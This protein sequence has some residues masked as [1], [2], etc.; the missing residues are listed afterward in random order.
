MSTILLSFESDWFSLLEQGEK[1]FEYRKHFP[2]GKTTVYFYVSKPVMAITGIATFDEREEL[3]R[4]KEKFKDRPVTVQE[5]IA[6]M[7][8]DCRYAVPCLTFQPTNRLSLSQ[9]REDID[10]FIVPRMY[11]Y[12][13][14]LPLLD[15]LKHNLVPTGEMLVH[16]FDCIADDDICQ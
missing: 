4:W 9:L 11:Y 2:K 15:Y 7:L 13:D 10:N 16:S 1:K 6:E 14:D 5:R 8:T 12:L 3:I